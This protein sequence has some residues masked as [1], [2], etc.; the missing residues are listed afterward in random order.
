MDLIISKIEEA[1]GFF[2]L[3]INVSK[4]V[5]ESIKINLGAGYWFTLI[6]LGVIMMANITELII[7]IIK[8]KSRRMNHEQ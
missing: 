8:I 1:I 2:A 3:F 7:L 6:I 4:L 5:L